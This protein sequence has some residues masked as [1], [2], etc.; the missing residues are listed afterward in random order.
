[1]IKEILLENVELKEGEIE[2]NIIKKNV[3]GKILKILYE[4]IEEEKV[5]FKVFTKEG[6]EVMNIIEKGVYYP[7]ANISQQKLIDNSSIDLEGDRIDYFYFN[8]GLL[9]NFSVDNVNYS[10]K[11]IKKVIILY[12]C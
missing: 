1:M 8:K 12:D 2:K 4:P 7:R 3:S 6:E 5:R 11:I 10:G 9:F